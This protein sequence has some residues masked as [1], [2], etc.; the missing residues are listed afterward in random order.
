VTR[1]YGSDNPSGIT[2]FCAREKEMLNTSQ[3][4][5]SQAYVDKLI[6]THRPT[7]L[8]IG[9]GLS[10]QELDFAIRHLTVYRSRPPQ[11]RIC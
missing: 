4:I 2:R 8:F 10:L 11:S 9:Y 5:F 1:I 7:Y 6:G 3:G